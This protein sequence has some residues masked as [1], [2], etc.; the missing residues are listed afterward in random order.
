[1][2]YVYGLQLYGKSDA[3][4]THD[5]TSSVGKPRRVVI[6]VHRRDRSYRWAKRHR[7]RLYGAMMDV[8][9]YAVCRE[10][11]CT[12][13]LDNLVTTLRLNTMRTPSAA[14]PPLTL[15]DNTEFYTALDNIATRSLVLSAYTAITIHDYQHATA[16]DVYV[17]Y[18]HHD[19]TLHNGD[20]R[21]YYAHIGSRDCVKNTHAVQRRDNTYDIV[22]RTSDSDCVHVLVLDGS[23]WVR[24]TSTVLSHTDAASTGLVFTLVTSRPNIVV[25]RRRRH[26]EPALQWS[27]HK[28]DWRSVLIEAPAMAA[29]IE[30]VFHTFGFDNIT[31]HESCVYAHSDDGFLWLGEVPRDL[32]RD[33]GFD[34]ASVYSLRT[35]RRNT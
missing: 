29:D 10:R 26:A 9:A 30:Q 28:S 14:L 34:T 3:T 32:L 18:S 27:K 6:S 23:Q 5:M 13:T 35:R 1:M 22:R 17:N 25:R 33:H 8:R 7:D 24:V 2:V 15:C 19:G 31:W 20:T 21:T 11:L 4:R 12:A 16:D